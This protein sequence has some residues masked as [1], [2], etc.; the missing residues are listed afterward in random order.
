MCHGMDIDIYGFGTGIGN[1]AGEI[2]SNLPSKLLLSAWN[3][4]MG[5]GIALDLIYY[6]GHKGGPSKRLLK[7]IEVIFSWRNSKYYS[8]IP[9]LANS[10]RKESNTS[11]IVLLHASSDEDLLQLLELRELL[12][13]KKIILILSDREHNTISMG[14]VLRPRL[15]SFQDSDFFEVAAVLTRMASSRDYNTSQTETDT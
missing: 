10:L 1:E 3:V 7:V 15:M 9:E 4:A 5:G 13:D 2:P 6:S 14:H 8:T 11:T 12:L